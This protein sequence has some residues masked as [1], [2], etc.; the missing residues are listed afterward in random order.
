M[1]THLSVSSLFKYGRNCFGSFQ[2]QRIAKFASQHDI[3]HYKRDTKTLA[4]WL[5]VSIIKQSGKVFEPQLQLIE[6]SEAEKF[7]DVQATTLEGVAVTLPHDIRGHVKLVAFSFKHYGFSLV[8][9][10]T[11]PFMLKYPNALDS[12]LTVSDDNSRSR[13]QQVVMLEICFVEYGF[14]SVAKS[15]FANNLKNQLPSSQR[16]NTVLAFGGVMVR[17]LAVMYKY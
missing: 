6:K 11:E 4:K 10:W 12:F 8:K 7:P 3:D 1:N 14:L 2:A 16:A 15:M 17:V 13:K 5:D 9:S